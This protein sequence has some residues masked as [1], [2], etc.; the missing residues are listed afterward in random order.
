MRSLRIHREDGRLFP[1]AEEL[2]RCTWKNWLVDVEFHVKKWWYIM[3]N[4]CF[5][6]SVSFDDILMMNTFAWNTLHIE[7][8]KLLFGIFTFS[9][10]DSPSKTMKNDIHFI[11]KA[12]FVLKLFQFYLTFSLPFHT[13]QIEKYK[14]KWNNLW[15]NELACMN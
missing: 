9:L 3:K 13:L 12:L 4:C 11:W 7:S 1:N 6:V 15:C 2:V 14:Q 8:L 10:N 5:C